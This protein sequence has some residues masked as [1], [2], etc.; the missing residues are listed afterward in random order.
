MLREFVRDFRKENLSKQNILEI[1]E[2]PD[3]Y[4]DVENVFLPIM[5]KQQ[6]R[7]LFEEGDISVVQKQNVLK[8]CF[9][10]QHSSMLVC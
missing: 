9:L 2:N 1:V 3:N 4:L 10:K 8:A 6:L 5:C 7:R